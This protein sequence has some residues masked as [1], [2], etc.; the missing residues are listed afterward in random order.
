M[1]K[2]SAIIVAKNTPPYLE[3]VINSIRDFASEIIVVD[4]G[5]KKIPSGVKII[6]LDKDIPYVEMIREE[7]KQYA[8]YDWILFLDPDEIISENLKKKICENLNRYDYFSIPRKNIIFGRWIKNSRWWPDYQ[9][10]LFKKNKVIWLRQIHQQPKAT[11]NG[12]VLE[13]KEDLAI[14]H[15]NYQNMDEFLE[16]ALRYAKSEARELINAKKELTLSTTIK[17][18]LSEFI[19][20]FFAHDGYQDGTHGFVLAIMQMFYYFFVYFYFWEFKKYPYVDTYTLVNDSQQFFKEG[21]KET[22]YWV[23]NKRLRKTNTLK[24][25]IINKL[26]EF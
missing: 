4:I 6:K 25:K 7:I 3:E 1:N 9:V 11:G 16:K 23:T 15:Y 8:T 13:P 22:N 18:S 26:L 5:L 24:S 17:K 14:T 21:F 10:R 12:L 20:R 19:S 2:I